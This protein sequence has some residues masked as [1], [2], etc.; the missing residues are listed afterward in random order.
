MANFTIFSFELF[1]E[2]FEDYGE[3]KDQCIFLKATLGNSSKVYLST[4]FSMKHL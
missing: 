4:F 3:H 1:E 2:R